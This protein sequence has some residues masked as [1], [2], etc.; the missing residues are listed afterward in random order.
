MYKNDSYIQNY[1][2]K[3]CR[4]S[5]FGFKNKKYINYY[6]YFLVLLFLSLTIL[7][8]IYK[9]NFEMANILNKDYFIYYYRMPLIK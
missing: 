8:I 6:F 5:L 3:Y 4:K 1:I 2:L 7:L 9:L